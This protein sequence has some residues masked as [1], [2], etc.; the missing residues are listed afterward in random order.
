[1]QTLGLDGAP[2]P[3]PWYKLWVWP[4]VKERE[5]AIGAARNGAIAAVAIGVLTAVLGMMSSGPAAFF[6]GLFYLL[7]AIG[8]RQLSFPAAGMTVLLYLTSQ[9]IAMSRG[10]AP[11]VIGLALS[12]LL[13]GAA[14]AALHALQMNAKDRAVM[15]NESPLESWTQQVLQQMGSPLWRKIRIG[16]NIVMFLYFALLMTGMAMVAAKLA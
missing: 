13:V 10:A 6:D 3:Q 4:D 12:L 16:F 8:I 2:P 14:R 11:G 15:A 1:M 9:I 5:E 7:A